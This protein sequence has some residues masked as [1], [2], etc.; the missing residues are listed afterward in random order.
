MKRIVDRHGKNFPIPSELRSISPKPAL[1]ALTAAGD[2][3]LNEIPHRLLITVW[4]PKRHAEQ[5]RLV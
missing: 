5:V 2:T 3:R 1:V 4:L